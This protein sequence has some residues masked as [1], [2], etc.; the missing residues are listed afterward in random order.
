MDCS[1]CLFF[2]FCSRQVKDCEKIED[3]EGEDIIVDQLELK[4]EPADEDE[5]KWAEF[6]YNRYSKPTNRWDT[7]PTE[8]EMF[9]S[10][11]K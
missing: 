2:D 6:S 4:D 3:G 7:A 1:N 9:L 10:E 5:T 11:G 8:W